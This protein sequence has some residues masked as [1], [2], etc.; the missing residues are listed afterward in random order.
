MIAERWSGHGGHV[1]WFRTRWQ[2]KVVLYWAHIK[3]PEE[4]LVTSSNRLT[5]ACRDLAPAPPPLP[6]GPRL[7]HLLGE[8]GWSHLGEKLLQSLFQLPYNVLCFWRL[9]FHFIPI[10]QPT[11]NLPSCVS[12][13]DPCSSCKAL[14]CQHPRA[15]CRQT[16]CIL[17]RYFNVVVVT[18]C[19]SSLAWP[20]MSL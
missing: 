18:F 11:I 5:P 15:S 10:K 3:P 19:L 14:L 9:N 1:P 8:V 4:Y 20:Q 12:H 7:L 16:C 2:K 13:W 17:S 6:P